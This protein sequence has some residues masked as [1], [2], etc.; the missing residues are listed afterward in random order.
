MLQRFVYDVCGCAGDWQM[1][2]FVEETIRQI[3]EKEN[4]DTESEELLIDYM[5]HILKQHIFQSMNSANL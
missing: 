3:R 5:D 4:Q 2:S 1:G